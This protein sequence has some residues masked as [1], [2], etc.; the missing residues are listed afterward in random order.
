MGLKLPEPAKLSASNE[1]DDDDDDDDDELTGSK[2][3][4]SN[5]ANSK[6]KMIAQR[7]ELKGLKGFCPVVLRDKRDL[8]DARPQFKTV[9]LG[10]VYNFSSQEALESFGKT[11]TAYAPIAGG[12]DVVMLKDQTEDVE[13]QLDHAA[14]FKDRLYLFSTAKSKEAFELQPSKYVVEE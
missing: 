1:E 3:E 6:M 9:Y 4:P 14:W 8:V 12:R 13:G 7:K 11:P 10:K 5:D 2:S